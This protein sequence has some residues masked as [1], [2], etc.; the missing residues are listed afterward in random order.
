MVITMWTSAQVGLLSESLTENIA[1]GDE[2]IVLVHL[3][4]KCVDLSMES[5]LIPWLLLFSYSS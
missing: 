1:I 5:R 3:F 4:S 2:E